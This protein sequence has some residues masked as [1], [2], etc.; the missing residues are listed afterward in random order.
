MPLSPLDAEALLRIAQTHGTPTYVYHEAAIRARCRVLHQHLQALPLRLLYAMKANTAPAVLSILRDEGLGLD[1]VSPAEMLLGLRLGYTPSRIL[2]SANN[3]TDAEMHDAYAKGVILNIGELSRLERFGQA[4][5]GADVSVRLNPQVGAGHHAHVITGGERSKF[6]IPVE[7]ASLIRSIA[8]RYGL[9][10]VGL[11]QHI[12]SGILDTNVLWQAISVLLD[13]A[14]HFSAVQFLNFGGG[15]GIPYRPQETPLDFANFELA[16]VEPLRA[17]AERH[18]NLQFW[19]EPGRF[20]VAESGVLLTRVNT[21]KAN[22]TRT[23]AG[24]DSG[25]GHL[26]RPAMY[27]A[28]HPISNLSNPAGAPQQYDIVGNICESA[29]FFARDRE[30]AEIRE[31]DVLA[32][33]HTGAYGMAMATEYNLRPLPAEVLMRE[34]GT[35]ELLRKRL[36]P[37][38][39]VERVLT[40]DYAPETVT[41]S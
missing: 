35:A 8:A 30:L 13:A 37:E 40:Q 18:P 10:I 23:F 33:H 32:L 6:G 27:N 31:G 20:L 19:F 4:Y 16:I 7:Q 15:L 24:T 34:D 38:E 26:L 25:M 5:P 36:T 39:L 9:N 41:L 29:D 14:E 11:H 12:G 3:M 2:Y 22:P 28:Y 17:Y 1:A 21:V